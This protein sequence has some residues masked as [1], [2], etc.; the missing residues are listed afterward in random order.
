[1]YR[2]RG[3]CYL[4]HVRSITWGRLPFVYVG[5][6]FH[7][8]MWAKREQHT[9]TARAVPDSCLCCRSAR[10]DKVSSSFLKT[11]YLWFRWKTETR[12]Q[13]CTLS[14]MHSAQ[15][16]SLPISEAFLL[17]SWQGSASVSTCLYT[18]D[19]CLVRC[20]AA[21]KPKRQAEVPN[22]KLKLLLVDH[23]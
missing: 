2:F 8:N 23:R 4:P 14:E 19:A 22:L 11:L 9:Q 10:A 3:W 17:F 5:E 20:S 12:S 15:R 6:S 18:Y 16:T 7:V 21:P 13:K 1:M